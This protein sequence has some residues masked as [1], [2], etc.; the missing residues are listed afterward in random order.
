MDNVNCNSTFT[1]IQDCF[2]GDDT[3]EDCGA[4]EGAG[5]YCHWSNVTA[6]GNTS[7]AHNVTRVERNNLI[8]T[9]D[10]SWG[11]L[12]RVSL[13]LIVWSFSSDWSNVL[14]FK[15]NGG[16]HD[17][18]NNG[19]RV[20]LVHAGG[21]SYLHFSNSINGIGNYWKDVKITSSRWY[22]IIIEQ[23]MEH[24]QAGHEYHQEHERFSHDFL[25]ILHCHHRWN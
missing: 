25:D 1:S 15:G 14:A 21:N 17:C 16:G 2:Y 20:P 19:D 4:D 23:L 6:A 3:T 11:P 24:N 9:L 18:C 5:V 13:E 7:S 10:G 12:F 22:N 8:A